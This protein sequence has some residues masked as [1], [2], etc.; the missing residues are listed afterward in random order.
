MSILSFANTKCAG[1][2]KG[3]DSDSYASREYLVSSFFVKWP[4]AFIR[5]PAEFR[6]CPGL[7]YQLL[8]LPTTTRL[9]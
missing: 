9:L 5:E 3:C 6:L 2:T 4:Q 8:I 1:K 7:E